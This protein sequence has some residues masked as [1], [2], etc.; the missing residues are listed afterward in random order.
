MANY[1]AIEWNILLQHLSD[2]A[3][4]AMGKLN[5][6]NLDLSSNL[7]QISQNLNIL[8]DAYIIIQRK[9]DID[10]RLLMDIGDLFN[11][12]IPKYNL[13]INEIFMLK[14]ILVL[15][16]EV[17]P[18]LLGEIDKCHNTFQLQTIVSKLALNNKIICESLRIILFCSLA[19]S[20]L[21]F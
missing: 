1:N 19:I 5:C 4:T 12:V 14:T 2:C 16:G 21:I 13:S 9:E 6:L 20:F 10:I 18:K 15:T 17:K 8:E 11:K 3:Q 7:E